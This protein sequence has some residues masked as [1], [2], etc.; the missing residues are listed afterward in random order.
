M[1]L[2]IVFILLSTKILIPFYSESSLYASEAFVLGSLLYITTPWHN[3]I[4]LEVNRVI[5][6]SVKTGKLQIIDHLFILLLELFYQYQLV[7]DLCLLGLFW[8]DISQGGKI[9]IK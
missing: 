8:K 9:F 2:E 1:V 6:K 4:V 7:L 5:K 3:G